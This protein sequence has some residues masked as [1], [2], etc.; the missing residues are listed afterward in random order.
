[1]ALSRS[2]KPSSRSVGHSVTQSVN[3]SVSRSVGQSVLGSLSAARRLHKSIYLR[4]FYNLIVFVY[5]VK[6]PSMGY[7]VDD[8]Q[9]NQSLD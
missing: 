6:R 9:I 1:M 8:D 5:P 7:A 4:L 3:Q 2:I